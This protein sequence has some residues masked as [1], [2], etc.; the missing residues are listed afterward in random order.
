[1]HTLKRIPYLHVWQGPQSTE[2]CHGFAGPWRPTQ[3]QRFVLSQPGV[4]QALM[5]HSVNGGDDQI[6]S[7]HF[8][9][10]HL[11]LGDLGLP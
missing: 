3:H 5:A 9:R 4:Q 10:L 7:G 11:H 6:C 8:V 1:M 2:E